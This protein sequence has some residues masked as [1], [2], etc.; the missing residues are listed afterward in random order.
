VL[1][2]SISLPLFFSISDLSP[3]SSNSGELR[4]GSGGAG[5]PG[6]GD[7]V[8]VSVAKEAAALGQGGG[9]HGHSSDKRGEEKKEAV[10]I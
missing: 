6:V 10:V 3:S 8:R 9:A 5:R 7:G 1:Q 4:R 2:H